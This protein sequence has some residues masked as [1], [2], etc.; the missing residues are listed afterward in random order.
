MT[1]GAGSFG[2][3]KSGRNFANDFELISHGAVKVGDRVRC[4]SDN[5][6]HGVVKFYRHAVEQR[7]LGQVG[8]LRLAF[9][10]Q[11]KLLVS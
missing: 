8:K 5:C 4:R 7:K 3:S 6:G 9:P 11:L 1:K 2:C 10:A